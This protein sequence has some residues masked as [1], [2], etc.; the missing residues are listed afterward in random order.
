MCVLDRVTR[1]DKERYLNTD[2]PEYFGENYDDDSYLNKTLEAVAN[3][4][5]NCDHFWGCTKFVVVDVNNMDYVI[6]IPF[7]GYYD[8]NSETEEDDWFDF[9]VYDYC[10]KEEEIYGEI[11][12][13]DFACM[14][15]ETAAIGRTKSGKVIYAQERAESAYVD[16]EKKESS[17]D[18]TDKIKE[19]RAKG[20]A[21]GFQSDWLAVA[22]DWYG[23]QIVTNFLKYADNN[24]YDT[25]ENNY[26]Y[27]FDGSPVIFDYSGYSEN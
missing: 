3:Q 24:I 17:K 19:L 22:I 8:Y 2:V 11:E 14:F 7:N 27:R 16:S 26:G 15:A 21:Y 20:L 1:E 5:K 9:N 23:E 12:N 10:A 13:E 4:Y 18:S 25:H 6:K